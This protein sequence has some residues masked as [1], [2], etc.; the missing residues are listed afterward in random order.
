MPQAR[1]R[2]VQRGHPPRTRAYGLHRRGAKPPPH[3]ANC[4]VRPRTRQGFFQG[5]VAPLDPLGG[6]FPPSPPLGGKYPPIPPQRPR[7]R[8][9]AGK[10]PTANASLRPTQP[11]RKRAVLVPGGHRPAPTE[12]AGETSANRPVRPRTGRGP[13][14]SLFRMGEL[15]FREAEWGFFKP[16]SDSPRGLAERT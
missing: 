4:P 1:R 11:E 5:G 3:S 9:R 12:P 8:A 6:K 10:L 13:A 14:V 16:P 2:L 7:A 15:R